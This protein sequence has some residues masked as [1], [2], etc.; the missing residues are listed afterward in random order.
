MATNP[1]SKALQDNLDVDYVISYRFADTRKFQKPLKWTHRSDTIL[2]KAQ[3]Q[4]GLEKLLQALANVGLQTCVRIGE[5]CSLLV[6]AKAADTEQFK[7][8]V[9]KQR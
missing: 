4:Q 1:E 8:E 6:F 2:A 7:N 9:Y 5:N 3:A